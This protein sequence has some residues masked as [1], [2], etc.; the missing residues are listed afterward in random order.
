MKATDVLI[1]AGEEQVEQTGDTKTAALVKQ[2]MQQRRE[3][4]T[5]YEQYFR[6]LCDRNLSPQDQP[7]SR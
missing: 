2:Y 7:S 3:M 4:E 1:A 6:K 5:N